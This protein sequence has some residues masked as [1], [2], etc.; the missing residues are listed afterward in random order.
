[1]A[2][3]EAKKKANKRYYN[4]NRKLIAAKTRERRST[5]YYKEYDD[6]KN[7]KREPRK[8]KDYFLRKKYGITVEDWDEL[9]ESQGRACAAC[10][11]TS[12]GM[13]GKKNGWATDHDHSTGLIRGILCNRCNLALGWLGDS[14]DSVKLKTEQLLDYLMK[15]SIK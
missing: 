1:M 12:P 15:Q 5:G 3:T 7:Q 8:T 11:S 13:N 14:H 10:F 6:R 9:F 4:R 2:L